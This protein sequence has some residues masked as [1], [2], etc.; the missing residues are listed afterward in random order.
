MPGQRF[1]QE[2]LGYVVDSFPQMVEMAKTSQEAPQSS[3][4]AAPSSSSTSSSAPTKGV[5]GGGTGGETR[6]NIDKALWAKFWYPTVTLNM[7]MKKLLPSHGVEWLSSRVTCSQIRNGRM[8]IEIVVFD[9]AGELVALSNHVALIVPAQRNMQRG[10]QNG[11]GGGNG[12][13]KSSRANRN[14]GDGDGQGGSKL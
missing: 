14:A 7:E 10:D 1:T 12:K 8:D 4:A 6:R 2:S 11:G 9:E 5:A 13:G 3:A